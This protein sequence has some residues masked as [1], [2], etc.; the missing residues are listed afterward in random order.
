M[1]DYFPMETTLFGCHSPLPWAGPMCEYDLQ[2]RQDW[3]MHR[4]QVFQGSLIR[5]TH[6]RRRTLRYCLPRSQS[7]TVDLGRRP[8]TVENFV[9]R[10]SCVFWVVLPTITGGTSAVCIRDSTGCS[11]KSSPSTLCDERFELERY[12]DVVW[13]S[14]R[15]RGPAR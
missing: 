1:Y 11:I 6:L 4:L 12:R 10:M 3:T 13:L 2:R 8:W 5:C 7:M 15:C 9:S 14:V